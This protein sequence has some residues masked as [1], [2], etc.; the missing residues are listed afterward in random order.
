MYP[1]DRKYSKEH[2]WIR[3]EGDTATIGITH[4]AQDQLGDIVYVELPEVGREIDKGEVL[5]TI[6]SVKAVSEIYAPIGGKVAAVNDALDGQPETV[7]S[8]PHDAGWYCKVA[9]RDAAELD[10]LL[11]AGAYAALVESEG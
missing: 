6:E 9:P 1:S 11:D 5:G 10:E 4:F 7:N 8:D 2:E 3:V